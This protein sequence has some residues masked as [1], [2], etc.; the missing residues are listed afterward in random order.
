MKIRKKEAKVVFMGGKKR[1]A[2]ENFIQLEDYVEF[3]AIN[4]KPGAALLSNG[5]DYQF[6]FCF[7]THGVHP[8][9]S[10]QQMET[11]AEFF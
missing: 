3:L 2:I 9:M 10:D 5:N 4:G 6:R 7:E 11:T 1:Q 8:T